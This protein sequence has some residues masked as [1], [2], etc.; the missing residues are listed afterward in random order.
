MNH[1][2]IRIGGV[3]MDLPDEGPRKIRDLLRILPR[4][5]DEYET[6]LDDNPIWRE[7]NEGIGVLSADQLRSFGVTGPVL[8]ASGV[9]ADLRKDL[10]YGGYETFD[11]DVPVRTEGDAYARYVVRIE[12][13]RQSLRIVEQAMDRLEDTPGPVMIDDPKV[14]WPPRLS[15]GP[16]GIGNDPEYLRHI[17]EESMEA[18]IHHFKMVTQGVQVPAGEVYSAVESPRGELGYF[19]VSDGGNRPY[20]VKI[21]DP[22]FANLQALP[23]AI[24]GYLI[25]DLIAANASFD[26]VM[27]GVDR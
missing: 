27:G 13:M 8:R 16:D 6:L 24:E 10:P 9:A 18:L 1:A 4:R 25:A 19:L 21:R 23:A 2:Y 14:G 15:V 7:R 12:E 26:P 22:S 3:L 17:M 5:I 11:F 20:R